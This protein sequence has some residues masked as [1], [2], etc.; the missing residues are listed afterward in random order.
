M[1]QTSYRHDKHRDVDLGMAAVEGVTGFQTLIEDKRAYNERLVGPLIPD[2]A[3]SLAYNQSPQLMSPPLPSP[4][5]AATAVP[6]SI[7]SYGPMSLP[8]PCPLPPPAPD[9][10]LVVDAQCCVADLNAGDEFADFD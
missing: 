10:E 3:P 7:A 2:K 5:A 9:T 8:L 6:P 1:K 4:P